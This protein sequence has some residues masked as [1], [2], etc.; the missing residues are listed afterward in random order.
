MPLL[1]FGMP[2]LAR[3]CNDPFTECLL[4]MDAAAPARRYRNDPAFGRRSQMKQRIFLLLLCVG[5]SAALT[6]AYAGGLT[7]TAPATGPL[8]VLTANPR[9]FTDGNGNAIYLTGS[10]T[11]SN[12]KDRG[13][14]DPPPPFDFTA[15][16]DFLQ[17]YNHN[18][19][20]LWTWGLTKYQYSGGQIRN[21]SPFPWPRTGPGMALDGKPR[22]DLNRFDQSYF[23]R[24]RSRILAARDRGIYVAVMLFEGH[25]LH[26]SDKP[27]CW[28][29]HPFNIHNNIN[30]IDGDPNG[31]GRGLEIHTL[32]IPSVLAIQEAY[33]R[34]VID[35]VN[36]LDNVLYEIANESHGGSNAWQNHMVDYVHSYEITKP[37]QHPVI[38]T[39][40]W[41]YDGSELWAS[42]AEAVSPGWPSPDASFVPYRDDPPAN[43]GRKVV[44]NDTDHLWGLGGDRAWVWKSFVRGLNPVYM[45]SYRPFDAPPPNA[46]DVRR[47]M[48]YTRTYG[49]RMDLAQ[50]HPR[51]DL[52]ST[53]YC[54]ANPGT[55]YLIYIPPP[56]R[57][58]IMGRG[59]S[60]LRWLSR[61]NDNNTL[62]W[63]SRLF[64]LSETV[65]VDLSAA[66]GKL[67]VEWF[68]PATGRSQSAQ[69]TSG[70]T[71]REFTAPFSGDAVLYIKAVGGAQKPVS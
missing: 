29:G 19:F 13:L 21:A 43:D 56:E 42:R 2:H 14:T 22:F 11:W 49:N 3:L 54:L 4:T 48:G 26:S 63:L 59:N 36:D 51:G 17:K 71:V 27:W 38:Y 31:D 8:R 37:E 40:A 1:E 66:S 30:G 10:H 23:D 44:I 20:R 70:G 45:D 52:A 5:I 68:N 34:K 64:G 41:G 67:S 18:F 24:L 12:F 16:L 55:E 32:Q 15:Y 65:S 57:G 46:D 39:A 58:I 6:R 28:D 62:S 50:M 47:S 53:G 33:V 61:H 25:S 35:T 60:V 7:G 9:Y 69:T